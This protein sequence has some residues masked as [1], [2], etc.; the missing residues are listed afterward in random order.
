MSRFTASRCT[1]IR[2]KC[3]A[4]A[5]AF[6]ISACAAQTPLPSPEVPPTPLPPSQPTPVASA[7]SSEPEVVQLSD[8]AT[9]LPP[10]PTVT[11]LPI[12][13]GTRLPEPTL[14]VVR[15]VPNAGSVASDYVVVRGDTLGGI[16][17][18][19]DM[20]LEDLRKLNGISRDIVRIGQTLK[21]MLPVEGS[22]PSIKLIP[23]SE[24]VNGK[25]AAGIDLATL[26]QQ[27]PGYLNRYTEEVGGITLSGP[28]IINRVSEQLS[29]N[30]RLLLAALE[31]S[32]NWLSSPQPSADQIEFP[33]GYRKTNATGLYFQLTWA[34][35]RLNEGYYGWRLSNRYIVKL[36]DGSYAFLGD[37]INAGTAGVQNWLAAINPRASW[38]E[39]M[40]NDDSARSF[41]TAYRR[42]FGDAWQYDTGEPLPIGT[43]QPEFSL[44]WKK[45]ELWY[46][47]GGPHSAWGRGSPWGAIDFTP[48][49]VF[50]CRELSEFVV[51]MADGV[52]TRSARGEVVQSLDP[53]GDDRIGWSVLYLHIGSS[54]RVATGTRIKRG[55]RIGHPSCEGGISNGAHV[56]IV[57][58]H[59]GEWVNGTGTAP[60]LLGG[61]VVE[62]SLNEYDGFLARGRERREACECKKPTVN[63]ITW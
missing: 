58:R 31:Y 13:L 14:D 62:E 63:G 25:S 6:A 30:P 48:S 21:V 19:F 15:G 53:S 27:Q 52:I 45:G 29:V 51:A 1:Q 2:H 37:G 34:A 60:F 46:L 16:A 55:E 22:S 26:V 54:D 41:M 33:L 20:S 17:I 57:R 49:T 35:A 4:L 36:E 42:L 61:W 28:E 5:L 38:L 11:P 43:R 59:N 40:Q 50:G 8:T 39:T 47:T 10:Q 44:P 23:D 12:V 24:L 32:G 7:S 9:P 3:A 18:Q 56:H